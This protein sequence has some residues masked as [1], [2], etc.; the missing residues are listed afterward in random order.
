MRHCERRAGPARRADR[1]E[2]I[3]ALIA[4]VGGLA[5]PRSAF[6]PLADDPVLLADPGLVLEPDL[7]GF[8]LPDAGQMGVQRGRNVFLNASIVHAS[9]PGWR[10]RALMC[11]KPSA[12]R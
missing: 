8:A 1:A 11:E 9:C 6:C 3:D 10:G 12:L 7:D 2:Q 5:R 4:R